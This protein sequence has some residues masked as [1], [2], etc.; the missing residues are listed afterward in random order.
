MGGHAAGEIASRE[1]VDNVMAMVRRQR[2]VLTA[3][4]QG[5]RSPE[6]MR[7]VLRVMES[8]IQAA[9][10]MVF[11][12]AENEPEQRGMGTTLSSLLVIGDV[13][14][15]GQVG[16]S[17]VYQVRHGQ[18]T[19]LTEDH[20]LVAWQVKQG[21]ISAA[22]AERSPHKN[23]ITRAVGSRDYVQVDTHV[24]DIQPG[25]SFL[26]C[27]D[28]LHGYLEDHEIPAI[29]DLGPA[30][31]TRHFI[32]LANKRGGRDNITALVIEIL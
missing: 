11:A 14:I 26:L 19:R 25:D 22:E 17:R 12:I 18:V 10:Y 7:R 32:E 16:D 2:D 28:G 29:V 20:T 23:V 31:A 21:I 8:A 27:S 9:T 24:V 15:T 30:V 5:D 4:Q 6:T 3:V 1:A 13:G